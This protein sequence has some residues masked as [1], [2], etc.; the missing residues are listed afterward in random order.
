MRCGR[1]TV[2]R[3]ERHALAEG[4]RCDNCERDWQDEAP[5]RRAAKLIF[6]PPLTILAGGL[7]F[8]MMLPI[9]L[10]GAFGAAV[11]CAVAVTL[12]FGIGAGACRLVDHSARSLFLRERA[13][14]LPAARLLPAPRHR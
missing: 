2:T 4:R 5:T 6:V 13:G 12:A 8:G 10:G 3:C 9:M 7:V 14:G 11:L 1:C